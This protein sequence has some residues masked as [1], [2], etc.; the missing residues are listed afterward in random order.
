MTI[1]ITKGE[2]TTEDS[3]TNPTIEPMSLYPTLDNLQAVV[4]LAES[5]LPIH[6]KNTLVGM[7]Y[8]YHNTLLKVVHK[9]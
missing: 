7:L 9:K 2:V 3:V 5:V 4:D 6:N 8:C 1:P